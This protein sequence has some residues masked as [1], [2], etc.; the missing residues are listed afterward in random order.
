MNLNPR[1]EKKFSTE[2]KLLL[3]VLMPSIEMNGV[4]H[5]DE[6]RWCYVTADYWGEGE[7]EESFSL[8]RELLIAF[9]TDWDGMTNAEELGQDATQYYSPFSKFSRPSIIKHCRKLVKSGIKWE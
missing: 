9:T 4:F 1:I 3:S 5:L 7:S 2:A 8:L 6:G